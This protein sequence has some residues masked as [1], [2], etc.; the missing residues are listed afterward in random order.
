MVANTPWSNHY[1]I[2]AT[3]WVAAMTTQ[4]AQPGDT[5][6]A[7]G[8]LCAADTCGVASSCNCTGQRCGGQ[9]PCGSGS[10]VSY[11]AADG[12]D[13]SIVIETMWKNGSV[14]GT[15]GP[16]GDQTLTF[17]LNGRLRSIQSLHRWVTNETHQ[18]LQLDDVPVGAGG[19]LTVS[20]PRN[21]IWT[22]T[23]TTGQRKGKGDAVVI[24]PAKN[25]SSFLPLHYD[26]EGLALDSLPRYFSDMQG[27]FAVARQVGESGSG[28]Q[29]MRQ[30]APVS[31]TASEG[32]GSTAATAIGD[33]SWSH[34]NISMRA[35]TMK[36]GKLY[37][38]SHAGTA[39]HG[40]MHQAGMEPG[41]LCGGFGYRLSV[42]CKANATAMTSPPDQLHA[43]APVTC[44]AN[45]SNVQCGGLKN[46][47]AGD[48]S[49]ELCAAAC[50]ADLASN[51][52]EWYWRP[53]L[54]NRT[55]TADASVAGGCWRG[56]CV[57]PPTASAGWVGGTRGGAADAV[58]TLSAKAGCALS[59]HDCALQS[60]VLASGSDVSCEAGEF[61]GMS[62]ALLPQ[63]DGSPPLVVAAAGGKELARVPAPAWGFTSGAASVG[64]SIGIAEFDDIAIEASKPLKSDEDDRYFIGRGTADVTAL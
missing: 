23:T 22:L 35:R 8:M 32:C 45:K 21:T 12:S 58:W 20:V 16:Y 28:N 54:D 49:A 50:C 38:T 3:L 40:Q 59:S 41:D 61:I 44:P 11:L 63:S 19:A 31:P 4:F 53:L 33:N 29:V 17:Q 60:V 25:F 46:D 47:K 9:I 13:I 62:V 57:V 10:H 39:H 18:F 1:E 43:D 52:H 42:T 36:P 48:A 37:L 6:L 2:S 26:F 5:Y 51:C 55:S 7:S 30:N 27:A 14:A 64:C 34:Y 15:G 56:K 24:P